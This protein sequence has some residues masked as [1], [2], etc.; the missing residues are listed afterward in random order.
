M[1]KPAHVGLDSAELRQRAEHWRQLA[2][3]IND[4]RAAAALIELAQEYETRATATER[5]C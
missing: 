1:S 4:E 2:K 3:A 5:G